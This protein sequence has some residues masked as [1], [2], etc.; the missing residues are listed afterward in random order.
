MEPW[1]GH[2]DLDGEQG[3]DVRDL[4]REQWRRLMRVGRE[5]AAMQT[6]NL[7]AGFSRWETCSGG[8]ASE[9]RRLEN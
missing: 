9:Q 4:R 2:S 3:Q 7:R 8:S 6:G 1:R 5:L